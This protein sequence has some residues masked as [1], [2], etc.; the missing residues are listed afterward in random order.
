MF[1]GCFHACDDSRLRGLGPPLISG[2]RP[3]L[4]QTHEHSDYGEDEQDMN[5]PAQ[6]VR[7]D[8][9]QQPKNQE[10][11]DNS[12]KHEV[13]LS[14]EEAALDLQLSGYEGRWGG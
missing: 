10:Q 13:V 14:T 7:A 11:G 2:D 8:H 3:A 1:A 5:E 6:S 12:P 4:N 9:S